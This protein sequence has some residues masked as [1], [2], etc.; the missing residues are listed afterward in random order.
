MFQ[1]YGLDDCYH[2]LRLKQMFESLN[3]DHEYLL[4]SDSAVAEKFR[5]L[6]PDATGIPQVVCNGY[7]LA[8]YTEVTEKMNEYVSNGINYEEK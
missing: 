4:I 6:F 5:S 7:P 1:I 3:I 8:D 2:C